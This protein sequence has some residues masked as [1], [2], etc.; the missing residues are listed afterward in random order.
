MICPYCKEE[1]NDGAIKC[2]HCKTNFALSQNV[3]KAGGSATYQKNANVAPIWASIT[4]LVLGIIAFLAS[5]NDSFDEDELIGLFMIAILAIIFSAI[6]F[7]NKHGGRGMAIAGLLT[8]IVSF[9]LA[10]GSI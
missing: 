10:L 1:I 9:I 6:S 2:K 5:L 4:G 8:G 7:A 3:T